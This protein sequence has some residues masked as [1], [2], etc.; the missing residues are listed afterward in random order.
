MHKIIQLDQSNA[1][2][3]VGGILQQS[4]TSQELMQVYS[5]T[6]EVSNENWWGNFTVPM[7]VGFSTPV[8]LLQGG[9]MSIL[10]EENLHDHVFVQLYQ[11][12]SATFSGTGVRRVVKQTITEDKLTC[13]ICLEKY[14]IHQLDSC[15]HIFHTD[16]I[17]SWIVANCQ[18]CHTYKSFNFHCSHMA[19]TLVTNPVKCPLC[20]T[21]TIV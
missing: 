3:R 15:G 4:L 2:L 10:M 7:A 6:I 11:Q 13:H 8:S 18:L 16:C 17:S 20:Q 12:W 21:L 1:H 14:Q 19:S 5:V 9:R